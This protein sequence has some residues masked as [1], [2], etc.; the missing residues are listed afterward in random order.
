MVT[1]PDLTA[2]SQPAH[3]SLLIHAGCLPRPVLVQ[4]AN[5]RAVLRLIEEARAAANPAQEV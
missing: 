5:A 2:V 3:S 4:V 1:W